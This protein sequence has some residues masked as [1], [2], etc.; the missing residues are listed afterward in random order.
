MNKYPKYSKSKFQSP[1]VKKNKK[2][3]IYLFKILAF[4]KRNING[5]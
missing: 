5:I 2:K 4:K 3:I 1:A